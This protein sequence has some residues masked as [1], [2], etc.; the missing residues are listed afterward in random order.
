MASST[1]VSPQLLDQ[2]TCGGYTLS[3]HVS[4]FDESDL[5]PAESLQAYVQKSCI[6]YVHELMGIK[7]AN[8]GTG[9]QAE[10]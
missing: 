3:V 5:V 7:L 9:K 10:L 1:V 4:F 8:F 2:V 6:R